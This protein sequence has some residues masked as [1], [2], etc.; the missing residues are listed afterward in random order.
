VKQLKCPEQIVDLIHDYLDDDLDREQEMILR[1]HLQNCKECEILFNELNKTIALVKSTANIKAPDHFTAN[2]MAMLPREK[3]KV[4]FKRWLKNHPVL[5]AAS[6]FIVLMMGS[7]LSAW[8]QDHDFSV[9]KQK[10]L[11]V[12]NNT[13]IVP[14]GKVVKG[15]V[16]V[17]NG[18][19]RIEGEIQGDA[20]V[21]N[22]DRYMAS[23]GHVTGHIEL[24]LI[25]NKSLH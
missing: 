10:N 9:S 19:L 1:A 2:V 11:I 5:A 23:A 14:K 8:N 20:T 4:G 25:E 6:L 7:L 17:R 16:F 15:D 18:N 12:K 3:K 13:A 21:I 24:H 22:G